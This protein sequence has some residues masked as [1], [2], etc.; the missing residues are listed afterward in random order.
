VPWVSSTL[1]EDFYFTSPTRAV[2]VNNSR[3]MGD[4]RQ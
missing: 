3:N 2:P 4:G 1:V